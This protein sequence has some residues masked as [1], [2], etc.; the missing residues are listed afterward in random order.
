LRFALPAVVVAALVASGDLARAQGKLEANYAATLA[1]FPVGKGRWSI[2]IAEDKFM[3][4]ATGA[5]AG[6]L[7]VFASGD[8]NSAARGAMVAGTPLPAI[9]TASVTADKRTEEFR[10]DA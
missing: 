8:G 5:T 9:F 7:R 6:M 4:T 2:E 10:G 1:G 3:A